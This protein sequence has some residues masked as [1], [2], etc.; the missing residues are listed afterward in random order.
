MTF[1]TVMRAGENAIFTPNAFD[2]QIGKMIKLKFG[3]EEIGEGKIVNVEVTEGG[4]AA[5][6]T[7]DTDSLRFNE[8]LRF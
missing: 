3:D 1:S 4:K 5:V 8:A 2:G 6:V 7:F